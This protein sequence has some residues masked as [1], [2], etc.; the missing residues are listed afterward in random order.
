MKNFLLLM[1]IWFCSITM[2]GQKDLSIVGIPLGISAKEFDSQ[3]IQKGFKNLDGGDTK[4]YKGEFIGETV[5]L[6]T[7]EI[8]NRI[9]RAMVTFEAKESWNAVLSQYKQI[10]SLF[11]K[12]YG[13]CQH[14]SEEKLD[15]FYTEYPTFIL[16]GLKKGDLRYGTYFKTETGYI[17]INISSSEGTEGNIKLTYDHN[18]L[19]AQ[20]EKR[21]L[22]DI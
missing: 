15:E 19:S 6:A 7:L 10:K 4:I 1:S 12:K 2:Y 11:L 8:D 22:D 21:N 13:E 20:R 14:V 17:A 9:L 18:D 5:L 3:L 16:M